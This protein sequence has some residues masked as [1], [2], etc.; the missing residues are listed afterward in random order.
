MDL[1][2]AFI[3]RGY[4]WDYRALEWSGGNYYL[5]G[6]DY[7]IR[8]FNGKA[9]AV[10]IT[11]YLLHLYA[12]ADRGVELLGIGFEI[13]GNLL[14]RCKC[15]GVQIFEFQTRKAIVPGRAVGNQ[16]IPSSRTPGLCN[17][18]AFQHKV[19][20]ALFTQVFTHGNA[21]LTGTNHKCIYYYFI[22]GHLYTL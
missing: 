16:R 5:C 18:V 19:R 11:H 3:F 20:H 4:R 7:A 14:F 10:G 13:I 6:F 21:S 17:A 15:V 2:D 8:S 1:R 12:G 22:N 9:R